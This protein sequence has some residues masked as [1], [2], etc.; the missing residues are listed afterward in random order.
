MSHI[1]ILDMGNKNY[2]KGMRKERKIKAQ[3][4]R[5]GFI[6]LRTRGSR[7]FADLVAINSLGKIR[8]LQVKPDNYSEF[9]KNKL[10]EKWNFLNNKRFNWSASFEII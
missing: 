8:F 4:E 10:L 7:G 6:V 1:R 3:L 9:Q 5:E 2:E